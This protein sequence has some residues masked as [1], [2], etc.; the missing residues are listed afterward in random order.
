MTRI[1]F[2]M[3]VILGAFVLAGCSGGEKADAPAGQE[4]ITDQTKTVEER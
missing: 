4:P 3:L 2:S 1:A